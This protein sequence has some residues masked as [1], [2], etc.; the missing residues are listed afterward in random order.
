MA[1]VSLILRSPY[2]Q[3]LLAQLFPCLRERPVSEWPGLL[4]RSRAGSFDLLERLGI[5][6]GMAFLTWFLAPAARF[7][8][9]IPV[10]FLS[11]FA[12]SLPLLVIF[13]G[14]FFWRRTRRCLDAETTMLREGAA[15]SSQ[16]RN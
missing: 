14:P 16:Q 15:K 13:A 8:A 4:E 3:W 12:L 1:E 2:L 9:S 7:D 6:A 11:Q 5:L 10:S